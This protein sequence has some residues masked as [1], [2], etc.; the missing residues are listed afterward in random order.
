MTFLMNAS[1][2]YQLLETDNIILA[3][4]LTEREVLRFFE[5]ID[6]LFHNKK[7]LGCKIAIDDFRTGHS[8]LVILQK[9][10]LD[11]LKIDQIFIKSI[12]KDPV[13]KH[14]V[15]ITIELAKSLSLNLIA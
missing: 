2:F 8:S 4:E 13:A 10:D 15:E 5:E 12:G 14:L 6:I 7:Q 3:L 9:I 11:Y 1:Q